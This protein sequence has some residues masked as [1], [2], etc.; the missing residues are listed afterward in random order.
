[1][2]KDITNRLLRLFLV[3]L[4]VLIA[5]DVFHGSKMAG[6]LMK[7]VNVPRDLEPYSPILILGLLW[8]GT[9]HK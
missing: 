7:M 8:I 4:A 5:I 9:G 2:L 3:L 6:D 1:M